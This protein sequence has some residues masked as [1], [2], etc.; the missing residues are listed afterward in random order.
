MNK[1]RIVLIVMSI[2]V[3]STFLIFNIF[4]FNKSKGIRNS[5]ISTTTKVQENIKK[6]D[7]IDEKITVN[8]I[9][10]DIKVLEFV[11]HLGFNIRYQE[12]LF[13]LFRLSNGAIKISLKSDENNYILIE[14]LQENDYYKAYSELK[15]KEYVKDNYLINYKFLKG[16]ILTFLKITKSININTQEYNEINANLDYMISS[17]ILTS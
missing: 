1:N 9:E 7:L 14:K 13:T 3:F 2:I 5:S 8:G 12:K 11:S 16:N 10:R 4:E 15:D 17:L 6:E